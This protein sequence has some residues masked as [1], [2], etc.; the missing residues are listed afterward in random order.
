MELCS[1]EFNMSVTLFYFMK[2]ASNS[3]PLH[4][5]SNLFVACTWQLSH[6]IHILAH[7]HHQLRFI[8]HFTFTKVSRSISLHDTWYFKWI[9]TRY[10]YF[11][12]IWKTNCHIAHLIGART[13]VAPHMLTQ[14]LFT[15]GELLI[16]A[17][18]KED[19]LWVFRYYFAMKTTNNVIVKS[20]EN[21]DISSK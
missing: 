8:L 3:V 20:L 21:K 11:T 18:C 19:F 16:F 10:N 2:I 13:V 14:Q 5:I 17:L 1:L 7:F 4:T 9:L 12:F 15:V 6:S